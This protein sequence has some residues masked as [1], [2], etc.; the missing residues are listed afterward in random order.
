MAAAVMAVL[1]LAGSSTAGEQS[2]KFVAALREQGLYDLALDYLTQMETSRLADDEFRERIPYHRG[3]TLIAEARA[4]PDV[5]Q[6]ATMFDTAS[7]Q[8]ERFVASHPES[9]DF[10]GGAAR[11]SQCAGRPGEATH[12]SG[13][14]ATR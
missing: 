4:T 13:G 8:L 9:P 10:R 2:E 3:L 14:P 5:D 12:R 7:K 1:A 6:R 11:A